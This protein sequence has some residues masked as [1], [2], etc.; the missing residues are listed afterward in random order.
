MWS[1]QI[2]WYKIVKLSQSSKFL[3]RFSLALERKYEVLASSQALI[4]ISMG[5]EMVRKQG[6]NF[7]SVLSK[8]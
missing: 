7:P 6:N 5:N 8:F 2:G 1:L 4:V 3:N